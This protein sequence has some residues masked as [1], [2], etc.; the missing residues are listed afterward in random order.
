VVGTVVVTSGSC[1]VSVVDVAAVSVVVLLEVVGEVVAVGMVV[2]V[3][4]VISGETPIF[5]KYKTAT[6]RT[7]TATK[8]DST[9]LSDKPLLRMKHPLIACT[10]LYAME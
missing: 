5:V 10:I 3:A 2:V 7:A 4:Y 6:A 1:V 8:T 9:L